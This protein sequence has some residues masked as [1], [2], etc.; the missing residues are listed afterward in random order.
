MFD[1][2]CLPCSVNTAEAVRDLTRG[3]GAGLIYNTVGSPYFEAASEALA[4]HGKQILIGTID[5]VVPFDILKFYRGQHQYIGIDTLSLS[6]K[7]TVAMLTSMTP[8]FESGAMRPFTIGE[9]S[10]HGL[11]DASAAYA[12]VMNSDRDRVVLVPR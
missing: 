7:D 4:K 6:T 11:E 2:I 9:A 3:Q 5:R 1:A 12:R 8:H 10:I